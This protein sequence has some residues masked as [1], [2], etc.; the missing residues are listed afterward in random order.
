[1]FS[2]HPYN[3]ISRSYRPKSQHGSVLIAASSAYITKTDVLFE[4]SGS[5]FCSCLFQSDSWYL[6]VILFYLPGQTS[7][8]HVNYSVVILNL[9]RI[10]T[11]IERIIP[12][13][14]HSVE[15]LVPGDF[16]FRKACWDTGSSTLS[17]EQSLIEF[18]CVDTSLVQNID[19]PNH[20]SGNILD[21]AFFSQEHKWSYTVL[22]RDTSDH[23]PII[24]NTDVVMTLEN[25][26]TQFSFAQFN[27]SLFKELIVMNR[28]LAEL[29]H[30]QN[31]SFLFQW[32]QLLDHAMQLSLPRKRQKRLQ[33]PF[34]YSSQ[35]VHQ[36]NT[37]RSAERRSAPTTVFQSYLVILRL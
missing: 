36:I 14:C 34:F 24:L 28:A 1:M 2:N 33:L 23:Y 6:G 19:S 31:P 12:S 10:L 18:I 30:F 25:H 4:I 3:V 35:T 5:C 16:N 29:C 21:L 17:D 22:E 15:V 8:F 7:D 20:K 26:E 13:A 11:E 27:Y 37:L 9:K 32:F